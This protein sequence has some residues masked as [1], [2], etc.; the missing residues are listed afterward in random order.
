MSDRT[1]YRDTWSTPPETVYRVL[2]PHMWRR[3]ARVATMLNV[4]GRRYWCV[5]CGKSRE[6]HTAAALPEIDWSADM[7]L[8]WRCAVHD[9]G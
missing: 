8:S 4:D 1:P 3:G 6:C 5:V 9:S 7:L 2:C